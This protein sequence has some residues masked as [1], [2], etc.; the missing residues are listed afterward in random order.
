VKDILDYP[1]PDP[2]WMDVSRIRAEA[3]RYGGEYAVLGGD[4]S[5]FWHDA[6]D[7]LGLERL[8]FLMYDNP[9][10]AK[11]LFRKIT[12]FYAEVSLRTFQAAGSAIDIFF[13]GNDFGSQ[14]GPLLGVELFER[15]A[16]AIILGQLLSENEANVILIRIER[17]ELLERPER[18][19]Q[20]SGLLHTVGILEKVLT[21]VAPKSLAG[22]DP[23]ELVVDRRAP[24]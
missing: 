9:E 19:I 22:A 16:L 3:E 13:I 12:D 21:R 6:I 23:S 5:P 7:F 2:D 24:G 15:F 14:T 8:Y 1:W 10:A 18:L 11:A 20:V 17:G 4:W